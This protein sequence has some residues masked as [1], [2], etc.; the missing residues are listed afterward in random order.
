MSDEL[1][2]LKLE[3][4]K[5]LERETA[6]MEAL[7]H[8]YMHKHYRW[9]HEFE[10]DFETKMQVV[11]SANQVGKTSTLLKKII[12]IAT[13]PHMWP[14]MWPNLA[15]G[16]LPSQWWYLYPS[17]DIVAIEYTEK[18]LPLLPKVSDDDPVFGWKEIKKDS[19]LIGIA[20]NSGINLYWKYYS[21]ATTMLQSGSCY[22]MGCFVAG[23]L[24]ETRDGP[25][26]VEQITVDDFVLTR[27]GFKAV[28]IRTTRVADVVTAVFSDGRTLRGTPDHKIWTKNRGWVELAHLTPE[29]CLLE[30]P[31][32]KSKEEQC[33]GGRSVLR[34]SSSGGTFTKGIL[35]HQTGEKAGILG[36]VLGHTRNMTSCCMSLFGSMKI[37]EKFQ[38]AMSCIIPISIPSTIIPR[39]C[40]LFQRQSTQ[41]YTRPTS[42]RQKKLTQENALF[43]ALNSRLEA[44][45]RFFIAALNVVAPESQENVSF[46]KQVLAQE[47]I[48]ASASALK[49]VRIESLGIESVYCLN[50][51][52]KHEYF[53][54]GVL[55]HNCDEEVPITHIPELQMRTRATDGFMFFVFT[56]TI[57]QRFWTDVVETRTIW[58]K[59]RVWQPSL[60]DCM[61]YVDGSASHWTPEKVKN[62]SDECI[63][64]VERQRRI[65]GKVLPTDV[66]GL[67][68]ASFNTLK[69]CRNASPI[70]NDWLVY[71]GIDYGSGASSA[72]HLS[73]I[74][75]LAVNPDRTAGRIVRLWRGDKTS[76]TAEDVVNKF[77]EM[78]QGMPSHQIQSAF[79]DFSARDIGT[80]AQRRGLPFLQANKGRDHGKSFINSLF[81]SGCLTLD[82][83]SEDMK[84]PDLN[85]THLE[86]FK[87]ITEIEQLRENANKTTAKDD[88]ID[89]MR[90][91][92]SAISWAWEDIRKL[93]EATAGAPMGNTHNAVKKPDV[94]ERVQRL[95]DFKRGGKPDDG[96]GVEEELEF[97]QDQFD[98]V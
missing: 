54:N 85:P 2:A 82:V 42:G 20:F 89:S 40:S 36:D 80:I 39:I 69:N 33:L 88:A 41:Q 75:F 93:S 3:K 45:K 11:C 94:D 95:V 46:A 18:W 29:D 52:E 67:Q 8:L 16:L 60:Y 15:K 62:A 64:E 44:V 71:A 14:K 76:T 72:A 81:K 57:G 68:F 10:N 24:V 74:T 32:C 17:S 66:S 6:R 96:F 50:V 78:C 59:A 48:R 30:L 22:L 92:V 19:K 34:L 61:H 91:A 43:V 73:A 70:P 1:V 87:V 77:E 98:Q 55:V 86:T 31:E 5:A 79:Y 25:K 38:R 35:T 58:P 49:F 4:I 23:T 53:A 7:P 13:E 84:V 83:W 27:D 65:F 28:N 26:P 63:S 9:S 47:K 90:Y 21:Q 37:K 97:W 12:R 56:P 51:K